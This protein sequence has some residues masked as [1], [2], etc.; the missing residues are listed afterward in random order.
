[1]AGVPASLG[2]QLPVGT[3][4]NLSHGLG[5]SVVIPDFDQFDGSATS[6]GP[7]GFN[8]TQTTEATEKT[9]WIVLGYGACHGSRLCFGIAPTVAINQQTQRD[10]VTNYT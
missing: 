1:M 4:G 10:Y 3:S 7:T 2:Y 5:I 8:A 9:T 6:T